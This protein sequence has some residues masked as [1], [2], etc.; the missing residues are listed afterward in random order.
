MIGTILKDLKN[1]KGQIAYYVLLF[2]VFFV[3][4]ALSRNIY[5]S[6]GLSIFFGVLVPVTALSYDEK[7]NWDKFALASGISRRELALSRY[8][9][10]LAAFLPAWG[11]SFVFMAI[12]ALRSF[13]N[14]YVIITYGGL[15]LITMDCVLPVVYKIGVD[16]SRLF[17]IFLILIVMLL[18]VGAATLVELIGGDPVAVIAYLLVGLGIVG[19]FVSLGISVSVYRHKDF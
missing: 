7:D 16:K 8:I 6:A 12:P 2:A 3:V 17:Y 14:L 4:S 18:S 9:L 19:L 15:G 10:G 11:L 1:L 13:E 5:Y